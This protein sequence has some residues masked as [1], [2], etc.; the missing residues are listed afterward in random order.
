VLL[1][2]C[3]RERVGTREET[4][5]DERRSRIHAAIDAL[6]DDALRTLA[7]AY[8]R[9]DTTQAP[10]EDESV[11]RELVIAGVVGMIDPPRPEAVEAISE[12]KRAGLRVIMITGDHPRTARC[13]AKDLG[14]ISPD[15]DPAET[16][17]GAELDEMDDATLSERS[18]SVAV[19]ARVAPEH[20]LRH[21][22]RAP[23]GRQRRRDDWR[24]R[25][26]CSCAQG[27][28]YRRRDGRDW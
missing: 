22:R 16:L 18:R 21:H 1:G 5:T 9:L 10:P 26:R 7:V 2:R 12:A 14:I 6:A 20:K 24:W 28:R 17:S 23:G 19:Y 15:V 8:R 25:E 11:E 27:R 3:T 13:I 4:L